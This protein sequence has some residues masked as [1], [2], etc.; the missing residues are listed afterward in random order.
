[1]SRSAVHGA[2]LGVGGPCRPPRPCARTQAASPGGRDVI[3]GG[4]AGASRCASV[5]SYPR[6]ACQQLS[7]A[8]QHAATHRIATLRLATSLRRGD[9]V[10]SKAA[11]G[12]VKWCGWHGMQGVR[13]SNPLSSARHNASS[14]SA[15]SAVCQKTRAVAART[16]FALGGSDGVRMGLEDGCERHP[17]RA[18]VAAMRRRMGLHQGI[19]PARS[20]GTPLAPSPGQ[21]P[22]RESPIPRCG[23]N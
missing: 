17:G 10:Q 7:A 23:E 8:L 11:G 5:R 22:K 1:V 2:G 18:T 6:S 3:A 14:T 12:L 21:P 4:A 9:V 13:G 19:R 15:L 16:L 20:A